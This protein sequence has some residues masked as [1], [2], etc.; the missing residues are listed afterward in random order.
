MPYGTT[1]D[2]SALTDVRENLTN[3]RRRRA[4]LMREAAAVKEKVQGFDGSASPTE[5]LAT[6][7]FK[8]AEQV[9]RDLQKVDTQI[10][11]ESTRESYLVSRMAG[12]NSY[13]VSHESFLSDP[14][15]LENL[16]SLANSSQPIGNL[17]LGEHRSRDELLAE[18]DQRRRNLDARLSGGSGM[19]A[20]AGDVV[21]PSDVPRTTFYGVIPSL[22]RPLRLLDLIPTAPTESNVIDYLIEPSVVGQNILSGTAAAET[23]ELA[24]KP[25]GSVTF[26]EAQAHV[27][28]V[29]EWYRLP[30]Q[31]MSDVPAFANSVESR[32]RWEVEN[33]LELAIL[34]GDGTGNNILGIMNTT[35]IGAPASVA[36][37]TV[38]SDLIRDAI[39]TVRAANAEPTAV[40]VNDLDL[41]RMQK[42]KAAGSGQRLDAGGAFSDDGGVLTIWDVPAVVTPAM[43]SGSALVGAFTGALVFLREGYTIRISDSDQSD[44]IQ[45]AVKLLGEMR[46]GF[47][48]TQPAAFAKITL[49]FTS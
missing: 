39:A 3:L 13:G 30:R 46:A 17:N 19:M 47:A 40:V 43:A 34:N 48:V 44:F 12:I 15:V 41:A 28:T 1:Q 33:R 11:S 32:L 36:G 2:R 22:K 4:D 26:T 10:G 23:A 8:H 18:F 21:L 29:A 5:L 9:N 6:P 14:A 45:N 49:G 31:T 20:A 16:R 27:R 25:S 37:D 38:N 7:E 24:V 42:A 35:G